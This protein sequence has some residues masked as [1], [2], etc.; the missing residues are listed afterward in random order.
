MTNDLKWPWAGEHFRVFPWHKADWLVDTTWYHLTNQLYAWTSPCW[1]KRQLES[2]PGWEWVTVIC[3]LAVLVLS[4]FRCTLIKM[5]ELTGADVVAESLKA[6]V[7]IA[8]SKTWCFSCFDKKCQIIRSNAMHS[9]CI[10]LL[11][12]RQWPV[13]YLITLS[14]WIMS[15]QPGA[16]L[17]KT[18]D[19]Y[20]TDWKRHS[21]GRAPTRSLLL[22]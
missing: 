14:D 3:W 19:L 6:Q 17:T 13:T 4:Q 21:A 15:C 8:M 2:A 5:T 12:L 1:P 11:R 7:C 18:T 20:Q 10:L 9:E 22:C 16:R